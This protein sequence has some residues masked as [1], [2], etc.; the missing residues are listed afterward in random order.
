MSLLSLLNSSLED[1][2][3]LAKNKIGFF[4]YGSGSKSK[5][6]EGVI[7]NNWKNKILKSSLFSTLDA[8]TKISVETYEQL[9][10]RSL[11]EDHLKSNKIQLSHIETAENKKGF[12][13][14]K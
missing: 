11:K 12:R 2:V 7:Q 13:V 1:N 3:E 9:H 14:V 6:F 10:N 8:R 4:S 5:V